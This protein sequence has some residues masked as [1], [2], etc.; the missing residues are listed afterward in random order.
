MP[1]FSFWAVFF[2][3]AHLFSTER[4]KHTTVHTKAYTKGQ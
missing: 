1:V 3:V 4:I 2:A